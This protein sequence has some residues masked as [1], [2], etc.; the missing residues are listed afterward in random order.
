MTVSTDQNTVAP[1]LPALAMRWRILRAL[2]NTLI[3]V[4]GFAVCVIVPAWTW[5]AE[6]QWVLVGVSLIVHV[7]GTIRI[8]LANPDLLPARARLRQGPGSRLRTRCCSTGSCSAT[9]RW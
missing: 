4:A 8:V 7:I 6:R 2:C 1:N 3:S 5:R 9:R